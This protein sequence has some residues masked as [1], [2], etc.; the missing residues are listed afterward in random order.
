M[1]TFSQYLSDPND[2]WK[3]FNPIGFIPDDPVVY[4]FIGIPWIVN[5]CFL[6]VVC[7]VSLLLRFRQA[8]S[9][10]RMQIKWLLFASAVFVIFYVSG[11]LWQVGFSGIVEDAFSLLLILLIS[12][13]PISIAIAILRYRLWDI[14]LIIQ[15][16]LIY[17]ILTTLLGLIYFGSVVLLQLVLGRISVNENSPLVIV[18][19]T[20]LI[21]ALFSPLRRRIQHV[22]DRRFYRQRYNAEKALADFTGMARNETDLMQLSNRLAI[23][24]QESL[25]P[26]EVSFWIT[27]PKNQ[28]DDQVK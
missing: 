21:A 2:T 7:A 17:S 10:E 12:F 19:S 27:N 4:N 26:S 5:L 25:Q 22:I 1:T 16:T 14:D 8:R 9:E 23:T 24:V 11:I 3:I 15:K 6:I 13:F 20:L 18:F 28:L